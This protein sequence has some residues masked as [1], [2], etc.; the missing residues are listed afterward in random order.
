[1]KKN[2][3][4]ILIILS[5]IFFENYYCSTVKGN[6]TDSRT[7]EPVSGAYIMI[8]GI[9]RMYMS[10]SDGNF[11]IE[12]LSPGKYLLKISELFRSYKDSLLIKEN[13]DIIEL[14]ISLK[15][16]IVDLDSVTNSAT[17]S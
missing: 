17:I 10:D 8:D 1:M 5:L 16:L 11:I 3:I 7:G 15:S 13:D 2:N 12:N 6:V 9:K 14:N 4:L